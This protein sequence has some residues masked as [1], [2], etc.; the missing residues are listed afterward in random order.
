MSEEAAPLEASIE[1]LVQYEAK[2]VA[3][4]VRGS[5]PFDDLVQ[6]GRLGALEARTRYDPRRGVHFKAFARHRVR[7]AIFD[8][9]RIMGLLSR[10]T[11][12]RLRREAIDEDVLGEPTP[13]PEGGP[14]RE[15]DAKVAYQAILE[16]A[17]SRLADMASQP[18]S[19][20]VAYA[21]EDAIYKLRRAMQS[22]DAEERRAITAIYDFNETGDSGAQMAQRQGTS[23]SRISRVH[24]RALKRLRRVL[25][26]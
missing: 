22:L 5:V 15:Q 14:T 1:L 10:R 13:M 8:G 19:P 26:V 4:R 2:D 17:T 20:E 6:W 18:D 23:R 25:Q 21:N 11:Y 3:K 9:L 16:L 12:D 24:R 7:G